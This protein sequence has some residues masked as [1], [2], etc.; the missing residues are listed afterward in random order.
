ML[1]RHRE[2]WPD[3][4]VPLLITTGLGKARNQCDEWQQGADFNG[5]QYGSRA[6]NQKGA[7]VEGWGDDIVQYYVV[8]DMLKL[9]PKQL[10]YLFAGV[11]GQLGN[12]GAIS[13]GVGGDTLLGAK[14][15]V[16]RFVAGL[17][18]WFENNGDTL[19]ETVGLVVGDRGGEFGGL[20]EAVEEGWEGVVRVEE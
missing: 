16:E 2:R 20:K 13:C 14:G 3:D 1:Q 8:E 7:A 5:T 15:V 6:Y 18:E 10:L 9:D 11:T 12:D 4:T 17:G 19:E